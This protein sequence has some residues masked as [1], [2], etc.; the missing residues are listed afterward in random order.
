VTGNV[1]AA[2]KS[3]VV[4]DD[5]AL[6]RFRAGLAGHVDAIVAAVA[7]DT[8]EAEAD[9]RPAVEHV[10]RLL[11]PESA[12]WDVVGRELAQVADTACRAGLPRPRLL[13]RYLTTGWVTWDL[14]ASFEWM[15]RDALRRLGGQ[16]MR[17]SDV[18]ASVFAEAYYAV[19]RELAAR[20]GEARRSFLEEL[21]GAPPTDAADAGRLRRLAARYGLDPDGSYRLAAI[22]PWDRGVDDASTTLADALAR[23]ITAPSRTRAT[24]A[25]IRLPLTI[26]WRSRVVVLASAAWPGLGR[27]ATTLA[28][29]AHD[30]WVATASPL[31]GGVSLLPDALAQLIAALRTAERIG[32]RGWFGS[33]DELALEE[34][35]LVDE[36]LM[37]RTVEHELGPVLA[38]PRMGEELVETL[39]VYFDSG[40]NMRETARRLHLANRT[41]A[42]R[43]E[44]IEALLGHPIDGE[45]RQR[46]VVALVAHRILGSTG[47]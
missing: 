38:E 4:L 14:A 3:E 46:L 35:M 21:L 17:G 43:L 8:G 42:Y 28:A 34:L 30:G 2:V 33:P 44:R 40:E 20:D 5:A 18:C 26:P 31:V 39:R 41:V 15:D 6:E 37:R 9:V 10:V 22:S 16:L 45:A 47:H 7:S 29:T 32:H 23:A 19:D 36:G 24:P 11:T 12:G 13:D 27:L 1:A 25:R